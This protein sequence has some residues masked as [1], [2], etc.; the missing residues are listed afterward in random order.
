MTAATLDRFTAQDLHRRKQRLVGVLLNDLTLAASDALDA[1]YRLRE[2][3]WLL[4]DRA[5]KASCTRRI[6]ELRRRQGIAVDLFDALVQESTHLS[7]YYAR[8]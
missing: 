5:A 7:S 1:V 2:R 6:E 3:H 8:R 4:R